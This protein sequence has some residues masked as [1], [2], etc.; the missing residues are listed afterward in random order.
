[1][2]ELGVTV[3]LSQVTHHSSIF[4]TDTPT[5]CVSRVAQARDAA[6]ADER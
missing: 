4:I 2:A 3:M 6:W 1:V 5:P